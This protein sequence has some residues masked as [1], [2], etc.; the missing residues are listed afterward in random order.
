VQSKYFKLGVP[1]TNKALTRFYPEF[2]VAGDF[3]GLFTVSTD[4]GLTEQT[5]TSTASIIGTQTL[6]W[7]VGE[8]D[9]NLWAGSTTNFISFGPPNSRL[10]FPSIQAD[11]YAFGFNMNGGLAP[12]IWMGGTG[13][14]Q[15]Q[16][17]T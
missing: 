11:S 6:L 15:Q 17:R 4:Y 1:G 5:A 9:V 14:Y 2:L 16:G 3:S 13:V 8:W 10:D 7:D 12:W